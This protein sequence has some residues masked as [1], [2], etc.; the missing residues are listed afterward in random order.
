M[1][2][3][4]PA[5][6]ERMLY[7]IVM[8]AALLVLLGLLRRGPTLRGW[9]WSNVI[10]LAAAVFLAVALVKSLSLPRFLAARLLADVVFLQWPVLLAVSAVLLLRSSRGTA[11][12]SALACAG[13]L[14]VGF[15]AFF[16]EPTWLEVTHV[17]LASEK[18]HSP[19]RIVVVADPQT[20]HFGEYERQSLRRA[21]AEHPD[22]LLFAGD[23]VQ[24][25]R[26]TYR[27]TVRQMNQFLRESDVHPRLGA[28]AI[29]GNVE[30]HDWAKLFAGSPVKAVEKTETFDLGDLALTCLSVADSDRLTAELPA[31]AKDRYH[32]VLG[33]RP[34][35]T[36][37]ELEADLMLAG[38]CHGG[39]V[40]L[41]L[42]GPLMTLSHVPRQ[43]CVGLNQRPQGGLMYVSRGVGMERGLAPR[44]RFLCRPELT[45][46]ELVPKAGP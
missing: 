9:L 6:V 11:V 26:D 45:V 12:V 25:D 5:S 39:Q 41:P 36:L 29:R 42:I 20:D 43:R 32:I 8:A 37:G 16:I 23:Y 33:H 21:F 2:H 13:V 19:L 7:N 17:R 18:I 3:W 30:L 40:R 44:L 22:L 10:Y 1:S 27:E 24:A 35:Y 34:D 14:A 15:D 28:F 38:H 46:I 4:N 31:T